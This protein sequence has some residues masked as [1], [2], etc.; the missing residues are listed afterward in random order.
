MRRV[1]LLILL[2]LPLPLFGGTF[3]TRSTPPLIRGWDMPMAITISQ[4]RKVTA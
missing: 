1:V 4:P 3:K 2:A